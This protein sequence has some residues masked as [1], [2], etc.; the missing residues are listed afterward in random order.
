MKVGGMIYVPP[1]DAFGGGTIAGR[2]NLWATQRGN[3]WRFRT[4]QH[5]GGVRVWRVS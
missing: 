1:E 3:G 2:V 4:K 5:K